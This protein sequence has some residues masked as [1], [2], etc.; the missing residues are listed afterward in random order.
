MNIIIKII[1]FNIVLFVAL[2]YS[3]ILFLILLTLLSVWMAY[4]TYKVNKI[5]EGNTN[6]DEYKMNFAQLLNVNIQKDYKNDILYDTIT[7][8]FTTLMK[9]LD[10]E[11]NILPPNQICI[12]E[13]GDW[14]ECSKE[15]GRGKKT[16][17]FNTIQK[18]GRTGIDCIYEDG[19][20]E[21]SECF[22]RLCK[23]NEECE[24]DNDCISNLCSKSEKVCTYHNMCMRD[25]LYNCNYDQC[26]NLQKKDQE[27][28]YDLNQQ[29]CIRSTVDYNKVDVNLNIFDSFADI[30]RP[31]SKDEVKNKL[32]QI[33]NNLCENM[34]RPISD[35]NADFT[36]C[37]G[38]YII[39]DNIPCHTGEN[40]DC[41]R[42]DTV[43]DK[44]YGYTLSELD[45]ETN[46][47]KCFVAD[48]SSTNNNN[49]TNNSS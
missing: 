46:F 39:T 19:Q 15:C 28:T 12:G 20:I 23:F 31:L 47:W 38:K 32:Y 33:K 4:T 3:F 21:T 8:K 48:D 29:K 10:E 27:I 41:V 22:N 16:R 18:A 24:Y 11:E 36:R 49:S 42:V 37:E 30:N 7:D 1:L 2:K 44:Y 25:M 5:I 26:L 14:G 13:L 6:L 43:T 35:C 45:L 17:Q 40:N 9:L 34:D